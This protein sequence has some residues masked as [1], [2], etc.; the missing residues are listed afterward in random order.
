MECPPYGV[1][2]LNTP[3]A[4]LGVKRS[5]VEEAKLHLLAPLPQYDIYNPELFVK[6]KVNVPFDSL[7]GRAG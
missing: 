6:S 3:L 2:F 5:L 1:P 4:S 7:R